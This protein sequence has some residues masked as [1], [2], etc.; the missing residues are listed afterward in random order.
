[1][2]FDIKNSSTWEREIEKIEQEYVED[3]DVLNKK[4][5]ECRDKIIAKAII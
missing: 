4:C 2:G 3:F 1:M 5:I